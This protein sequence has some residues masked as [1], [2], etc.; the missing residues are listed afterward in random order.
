MAEE[1]IKECDEVGL[2]PN[3]RDYLVARGFSKTVQI[4]SIAEC[5]E[6]FMTA[7]FEPFKEGMEITMGMTKKK[8]IMG[9]DVDE[10]VVQTGFKCLWKKCKHMEKEE[11]KKLNPPVQTATLPPPPYGS[12]D[13]HQ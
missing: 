6:D 10:L 5:I 8:W 4:A 2:L 3:A 1:L 12:G 9:V 11:E 13:Q 7:V